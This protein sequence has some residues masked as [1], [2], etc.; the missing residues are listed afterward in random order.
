MKLPDKIEKIKNFVVDPA[1]R[2]YLVSGSL[3]LAAVLYFTC[4][5]IPLTGA[6]L[7]LSSDTNLLEKKISIVS[8]KITEIPRMTKKLADLKAG[9]GKFS[10][11]FPAQKE[12][13]TLL[14][15]FALMA[16]KADIQILSITPDE[17][18]PLVIDSVD[19]EYYSEMPIKI[20][21][22]GGYHQ[23]ARFV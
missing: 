3:A 23:M 17:L 22:K 8:G 9:L 13:T 15:S 10:K 18:K 5:V 19:S 4:F 14:E 1:K 2:M 7:I 12:I 20:T 16:S 21:A 11:S 6:V